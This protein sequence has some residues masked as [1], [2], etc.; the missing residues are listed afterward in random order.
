MRVIRATPDS[1]PPNHF[2]PNMFDWKFN[3]RAP[4][5]KWATDVKYTC[6]SAGWVYL[7]PAIDRVSH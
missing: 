5:R 6:T 3:G 2:S 4:S 1:G 7:E